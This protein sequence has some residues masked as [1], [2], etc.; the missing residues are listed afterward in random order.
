MMTPRKYSHNSCVVT[1]AMLDQFKPRELPGSDP[2]ETYEETD[3]LL[4]ESAWYAALD[5]DFTCLQQGEAG[6]IAMGRC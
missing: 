3:V 5:V 1:I 2:G 6:W 4:L